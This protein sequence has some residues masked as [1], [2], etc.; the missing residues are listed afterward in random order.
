MGL[1]KSS[2]ERRLE[3][4]MK[5]RK[6]LKNVQRQIRQLERDEKG[7]IDKAKRAKQ[8]GD[9]TQLNFI[10]A[11][12][13]RTASTRRMME[14]QLLNMETFNQLRGQ[15]EVQAEFARN[16]DMIAKSI[17]EAYGS[18]NM[19][20]VSKNCSKAVNQYEGMQQT[21]EM[22]MDAQTDSMANLD[23]A[24]SDDLVSDTEIDSLIDDQIVQE[25]NREIEDAVGNRLQALK[26]R[27]E[28]FK[29]KA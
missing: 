22:L 7:F 2:E 19:A 29:D 27:V 20:E 18:V 5:I 9:V 16:L 8:L 26:A 4:E 6:G 10:K 25:E 23:G 14:R 3:R 24:Q 1:F 17:G 11:N 13:K 15:A 12:L 28:K 21:M